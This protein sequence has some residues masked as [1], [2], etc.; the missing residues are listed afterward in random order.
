MSAAGMASASE[1][2]KATSSSSHSSKLEDNASHLRWFSTTKWYHCCLVQEVPC[3]SWCTSI[4]CLAPL[5]SQELRKTFRGRT[6]GVQEK[7]VSHL[8]VV[9][10]Q[11][12]HGEKTRK[13][14]HDVSCLI[15]LQWYLVAEK[16]DM[17]LH[18]HFFVFCFQEEKY[19]GRSVG[20]GKY[21]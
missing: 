11:Q 8:I 1:I 3:C 2:P 19:N 15:D 5:V 20:G 9:G 16:W 10:G 12:H 6:F 14:M 13:C 18:T 17:M 21:T 7:G 4:I